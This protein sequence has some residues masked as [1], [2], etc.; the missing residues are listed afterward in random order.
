MDLYTQAEAPTD[1]RAF[2][3]HDW[4]D[5]PLGPRDLWPESLKTAFVIVLGSR[6]P[7]VIFWGR[8]L[9][10]LYN[11]PYGAQL[12]EMHSREQWDRMRPLLLRVL[13]TGEAAYF[14]DAAFMFSCSPI[15][16]ATGVAGVFCTV[17]RAPENRVAFRA[18]VDA[19]P[20]MIWTAAA[21]GS[22]QY[23]NAA[24]VRYTGLAPTEAWFTMIHPDDRGAFMDEWQHVMHDEHASFLRDYRLWHKFSGRYRWVTAQAT[25]AR[26][27][28]EQVWIGTT[29][30]IDE[31]KRR[32]LSNEFLVRAGVAL[33]RTLNIDETF[34]RLANL[35]VKSFCDYC[36]FYSIEE[37]RVSRRVWKHRDRKVKPV[38]DEAVE[39]GPDPD[40]P[41]W[42][43]AKVVRT[44]QP[45]I[46][47]R[48]ERMARSRADGPR[49]AEAVAKLNLSGVVVCPVHVGPN[50]YG[51][52][53][54]ARTGDRE[55]FDDFDLQTVMQLS[56]RAAIA[57]GNA[58]LFEREHRIALSFQSAAL[59]DAIP[60]RDGVD[61][62]AHYVAGRSEARVGG[63]WYDVELLPDGRMLLSVGDV[64]G[65][66]LDAA[67][68]MSM[69]RY[70]IRSVAHVYADPAT[71]LEAAQR[72]TERR[73]GEHFITAFVGVIDPALGRFTYC[74]AGHVRPL[75]LSRGKLTELIGD[76]MPIGVGLDQH[77]RSVMMQLPEYATLVLYTDG[78]VEGAGAF[79]PGEAALHTQ[80]FSRRFREHPTARAL[81]DL[82]L[83]EGARDDV[84]ILLAHIALPDAESSII[85]FPL[86][87]QTARD[88]THA[89]DLICHTIVSENLLHGQTLE[90]ARVIIG[91]LTANVARH[92]PGEALAVIDRWN[93]YPVFHL[94]DNGGGF[95]YSN[96]L[97]PVLSEN[98]RGLFI[99]SALAR[100]L[101]VLPDLNGGS[102]VLV[103]FE[104]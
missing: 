7:S 98:G 45:I 58:D 14:E 26:I 102:H 86:S 11:D 35:A 12:G 1:T 30:D 68:I 71:I 99:A 9:F 55:P 32:E 101:E 88:A 6:F 41:D 22:R 89:R 37:G 63:D 49:Y 33:N 83:P 66:G 60:H 43:I 17:Q 64:S 72:A 95:R 90:N 20:A 69:V 75:L 56:D 15:A 42:M 8:E 73:L 29:I 4:S 77:W 96:R 21:D 76:G 59:P 104:T 80:L 70:A 27:G 39:H 19:L 79:L 34:Q 52:L 28:T 100:R 54:F 18:L 2:G 40:D 36:V 92:A 87:V 85:R 46:W 5:T 24:W 57:L 94:V 16:D 91:E 53:A 23:V 10:A 78:L 97:P 51:A 82:M 93:Q 67:V 50:V 81:Y 74:N 44:G 62:D 3:E 61:I 103:V 84:A 65:S 47:H 38:L 25:R 31:R 13:D 48:G